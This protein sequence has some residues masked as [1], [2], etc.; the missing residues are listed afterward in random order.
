M[1]KIK[2][3]C[4]SS[5]QE[6]ELAIKQ[7]AD[8]IGLVSEM[9]SGPGVIDFETIVEISKAITGKTDTF[10]LTS[11]RSVEEIVQQ[12]KICRTSTVQICDSLVEGTYDDIKSELPDVK[13]VQVIHVIDDDSVA[14]AITA[15]NTAD[16]L[17]LD[18]GNQKLAVKELG[19]TGR[20]HNWDLS[21]QIVESVSVPVYLAGGLNP[22]NVKSAVEL[23]HPY[24][25][26]ICSGVR[27]GGKLD[28]E[29]LAE[30]I[31]IVKSCI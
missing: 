27:T 26:D 23:V 5:I 19:G 2:I 29:K 30:Y 17:L 11:K 13:V 14:E 16:A 12:L 7:G 21:K 4:I 18:S 1:T 25:V 3:C 10:L 8:A 31:K 20:T 22:A 24:G 28:E 9:P 15:A 6:A